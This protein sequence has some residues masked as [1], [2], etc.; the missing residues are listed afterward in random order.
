MTLAGDVK[1][2]EPLAKDTG[3]NNSYLAA[4]G[5]KMQDER[6]FTARFARGAEDAERFVFV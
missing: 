2:F 6:D 1:N 3:G 4:N 5:C